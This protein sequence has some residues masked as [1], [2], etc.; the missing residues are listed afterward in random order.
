MSNRDIK[1]PLTLLQALD[2]TISQVQRVGPSKEDQFCEAYYVDLHGTKI[3]RR[4][5]WGPISHQFYRKRLGY[6]KT[7][8]KMVSELEVGERQSND[9]TGGEPGVEMEESRQQPG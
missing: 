8:R 6:L 5:G 4:A 7:L 1:Y 2:N 3:T 9:E